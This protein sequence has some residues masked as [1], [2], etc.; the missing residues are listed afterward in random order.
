MYYI[1]QISVAGERGYVPND[2][3][4]PVPCSLYLIPY[5]LYPVPYTLY[6]VLYTLYP[7]PYTLY[8]IPYTL[9]TILYTLYPVP[10]TLY[11]IPC[12]LYLIP[13]TL[14]PFQCTTLDQSSMQGIERKRF[15]TGPRLLEAFVLIISVVFNYESTL[16]Q[17]LTYSYKK[18]L[19]EVICKLQLE[20]RESNSV[21]QKDTKLN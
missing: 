17:L 13:C 18:I 8:P 14:Y 7:I 5:T 19:Q 1:N 15:G 3:L 6:P 16:S 9:Y 4:Y 20:S 2:A 12:A 11:P 10:F 21:K